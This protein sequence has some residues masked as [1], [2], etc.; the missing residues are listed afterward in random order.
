MLDRKKLTAHP[1]KHRE[2][3]ARRGEHA[4]KAVEPLFELEERWKSLKAEADDLRHQQKEMGPKMGKLDKSGEEFKELRA[5]MSEVSSRVKAIEGEVKDL[6]ERRRDILLRLPN[7][8]HESVPDG[9]S[10]EDNVE[11]D[12]WGEVPSFDFQ[13]LAHWELGEKLGILDF[14]TAAKMSGSRFAVLRGAGALLERGLARFMLDLHTRE[15]GYTEI[16]PPY[17]VKQHAM[18]GTAQ[19]PNLA[20]D[21]YRTEGDDP[22]YLIPTAEVPLVNLHRQEILEPEAL[23]I[24]Y[25]AYTPCFRAEAGSHGQ[26][27]R[28]LIR[29]HQFDKVELVKIAH[30][31][32]SYE[33]LET[34]RGHAEEV[35][36]R[37]ELPYRTMLLCSGDMG[38]A[39]AKT[40]DL[41][42]WIPAQSR[43]R[44][45]SSCSNCEGFQAR[46]S[47]IRYRHAKGDNRLCHTL[48]GSGLAVGRTLIAVLENNQQPDGSVRIPKALRPYV[49]DLEVI[50]PA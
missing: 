46:R 50:E 39:A 29:Q 32:S 35:L 36:R 26:D 2:I 22:Y 49:N 20:D 10:E 17:L 47:R 11:I 14:E 44:E 21:C 15:H 28:G 37:L 13:P 7:L 12:R 43:Y 25:V 48:N 34:L 18:E 42:V 1:D 4:K 19:L 33:Q 30:P 9:E 40:Y 41:E 27:V 23:P 3:L 38:F 6:E 8:P 45:I 24:D 16:W 31:D 5:K